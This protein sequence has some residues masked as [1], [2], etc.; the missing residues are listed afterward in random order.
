MMKNF[1]YKWLLSLF[2]LTSLVGCITSPNPKKIPLAHTDH[3]IHFIYREWHTSILLDVEAYARHSK[4]LPRSA[5]LQA[6]LQQKKYM[7]IGW[8]DGN[9]FTG[10]NKTFGAATK[11]LIA[12]DYSAIQVL[13]YVQDP[14]ASIPAETRVPLKITDKSMRRLV[15]YLDQSFLRNQQKELIELPAYAEN[16]GAFFQAKGHYSLLSNCNTWSSR[17][18]QFA[19][20]PIRSR[21]HLTAQSV[22]EQARDISHYQQQKL[23][24]LIPEE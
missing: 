24:M 21:L 2:V 13:G 15:R 20:L 9:Y 23:A 7:R 3:T 6:Q 1:G 14:F 12:S 18:L 19:G 11:A 17:A 10:K 22:F 8:G 16:T 4:L 5:L